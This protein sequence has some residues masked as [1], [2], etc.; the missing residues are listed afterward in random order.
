MK[1]AEGD[2]ELAIEYY[3]YAASH[4]YVA[5]SQLFHDIAGRHIDRAAESLPPEVVAAAQERGRKLDP[6]EVTEELLIELEAKD[7][8]VNNG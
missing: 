3:V 5:D 1:L 6:Q 7:E 4:R 2:V 8:S